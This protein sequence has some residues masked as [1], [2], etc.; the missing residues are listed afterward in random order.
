M[1]KEVLKLEYQEVFD[2]VAVRVVYQ[3]EEI[4][5]RGKFMDSDLSVSSCDYPGFNCFNDLYIRGELEKCDN[6]IM[7]VS[8]EQAEI[9][10]KKVAQINKKYGIKERWRAEREGLYYSVAITSHGNFA[11]AVRKDLDFDLD[12]NSH[13][14]NNYFKNREQV[15]EAIR[16]I[17]TTLAD[18]QKELLDEEDN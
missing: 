8:I 5:P 4:L 1:I 6:E 3:D 13:Q 16:R 12:R 10:K 17:E 18:Y 11:T 14:C 9:I 15:E 2:K 7:I